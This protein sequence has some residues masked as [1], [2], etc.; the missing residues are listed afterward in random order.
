MPLVILEK[1]Y[2]KD[3]QETGEIGHLWQVGGKEVERQWEWDDGAW[4]RC[5]RHSRISLCS[6]SDSWN[7][8]DASHAP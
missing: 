1:K 8:R 7:R 6:S 4:V 5:A 2:R 3:K